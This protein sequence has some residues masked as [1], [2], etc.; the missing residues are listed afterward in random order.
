MFNKIL[1]A[2]RGEIALRIIRAC[3]EL[4]IKTVAV[5]SSADADSLHVKLAD[6]AICIGPASPTESYLVMERLIAACEVT[7]ADAIHPGY[8]FLSENAHFAEVCQSC[9]IKFIGP[10]SSAITRMGDKAVARETMRMAKVPITPGSAGVLKNEKEALKVAHSLGY[11]VIIKAV[12]GGGGKG[13]RVAHN[14]GSLLQGFNA[15]KMEAERSFKSSELYMEKYIES[16]K[17]IEVQILGD[18]FGNVIHLGERD[19]SMQRRHQKM[20][21]EAPSKVLSDNPKIRAMICDAAVRA[22]KLVKYSSAGTIEFLF[23][24]KEK[25]FYFM[26]M[27]T[28]VQ[29]EHPVTEMLTGVDIIKQQILSAAGE[30]MTIKQRDIDERIKKGHAIECRVNAEDTSNNFAPSPGKVTQYIVPGGFGVRVDSHVYPGY[31]ISPYY[32]S[33]VAKLIVYGDTREEAIIRARRALGEYVIKGI[34][35]SIPFA[36]FLLGTENFI[37]GTYDTAYLGKLLLEGAFNPDQID[38]LEV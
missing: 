27:N 4:K 13:M 31:V 32:D 10:S 15:A 8:G 20:V 37:S 36:H 9:K 2:N 23:D 1:I 34:K 38:T 5:Y 25:K 12:A 3:R 22:A 18:E 17:H 16:A 35:T 30:K 29:V 24:Q 7:D 21:E 33:M 11:P 19:C 26:E 6:E 28:R 14:D